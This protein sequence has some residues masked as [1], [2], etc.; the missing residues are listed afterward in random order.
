MHHGGDGGLPPPSPNMIGPETRTQVT[1]SSLSACLT[2]TRASVAP[3]SLDVADGIARLTMARP[4]S[5]NAFGADE[6]RAL[7]G[8]I[9]QAER[10]DARVIVLRSTARRCFSVG[11]EL[12]TLAALH[13]KP[14]T[15][16][17]FRNAMRGA[18]S[19]IRMTPA[20]VIAEISGDCVGLGLA[21]ATACDVR[22][23]DGDARFAADAARLGIGYPLEDIV[24]L[25]GLVGEG[26]AA[27]ML[28]SAEAI[29][30][31]EA[32]RIGLLDVLAPDAMLAAAE[33]AASIATNAP[34]SVA[35]L[36]LGL[37]AASTGCLSDAGHN[38]AFDA[39]LG[40]DDCAEGVAAARS[41]RTPRFGA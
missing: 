15:R 39:A 40:S 26:Q 28:Y 34:A 3:L 33:L 6:L 25:R 20:P 18:L 23:A 41:G 9:E 32:A 22:V 19:A 27:R 16:I 30:A 10:A 24:R 7:V 13:A 31:E 38:A 11:I 1:Q 8:L 37:E 21:L 35:A 17:P 2:P 5:G 14:K 29:H 36:K 4:E 12:A